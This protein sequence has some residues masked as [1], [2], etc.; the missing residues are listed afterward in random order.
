MIK[1]FSTMTVEQ[2]LMYETQYYI[3]KTEGVNGRVVLEP[4]EEFDENGLK[5]PIEY[6]DEIGVNVVLFP[7]EIMAN[8][9]DVVT[10]FAV[11]NNEKSIIDHLTD[12]NFNI[13]TIYKE[14]NATSVGN[15]AYAA[16]HL[17]DEKVQQICENRLNQIFDKH[18]D[19]FMNSIK[20]NW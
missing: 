19:E 1:K 16:L 20:E 12:S 8:Y 4:N 17:K 15:L 3:M 13:D 7:I 5:F 18:L 9:V 2:K 6:L 14:L 11:D 10:K